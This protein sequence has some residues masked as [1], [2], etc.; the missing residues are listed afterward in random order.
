MIIKSNWHTFTQDSD[1]FLA[2]QSKL[3]DTI[4]RLGKLGVDPMGREIDI[5]IALSWLY[6]VVRDL[7]VATARSTEKNFNINSP[8]FA[9]IGEC[10]K[11][12]NKIVG[13][14]SV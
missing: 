12:L 9:E 3:Q 10:H 4:D 7:Y 5:D 13:L 6:E 11:C 14:L 2:I 1:E 8:R